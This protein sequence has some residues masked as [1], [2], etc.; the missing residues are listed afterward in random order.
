M[1]LFVGTTRR[2]A[3]GPGDAGGRSGDGQA[4]RCGC[5]VDRDR[6]R[7]RYHD[8]VWPGCGRPCGCQR[9]MGNPPRRGGARRHG[10][11]GRGG[12]VADF[13]G[14]NAAATSHMRAPA[15][16]SG[17]HQR[18]AAH[19]AGRRR[20]HRRGAAE[21]LRGSRLARGRQRDRRRS[22]P[23]GNPVRICDCRAPRADR[24]RS[25]RDA[26]VG[27]RDRPRPC[28]PPARSLLSGAASRRATH[29]SFHH[30]ASHR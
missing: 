30:R 16:R 8:V 9:R 3:V 19:G 28:G 26:G 22:A 18:P 7:H 24:A 12:L 29:P 23:G 4:S 20:R 17:G 2:P 10:C 15:I 5:L 21:A 27:G 14:A 25:G 13:S 6:R 1:L 11:R